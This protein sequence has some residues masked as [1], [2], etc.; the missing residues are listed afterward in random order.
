MST[1]LFSTYGDVSTIDTSI[2]Q[3]TETV[4]MPITHKL[5]VV[6][7]ASSAKIP[8]FRIMEP[9]G[10]IIDESLVPKIE[11]EELLKMYQTMVRLQALDDVFY[12]AQRQGRISFYMQSSGEEAIHLGTYTYLYI[13]TFL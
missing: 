10:K 2:F 9:N 8:V 12:N 6:D 1:K 3:H 7:T 5:E 4:A 13:N 11:K